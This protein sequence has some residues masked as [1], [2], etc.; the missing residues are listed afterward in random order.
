MKDQNA[1]HENEERQK[2]RDYGLRA[3]VVVSK[4]QTDIEKDIRGGEYS[5]CSDDNIFQT[6][7][8]SDGYALPRMPLI[9]DTVWRSSAPETFASCW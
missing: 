3:Q 5:Q 1:D 6:G 2:R 8:L 9:S 7:V 4:A